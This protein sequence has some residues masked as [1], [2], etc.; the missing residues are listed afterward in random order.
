MSYSLSDT[1]LKEIYTFALTLG[2]A[3]G[4]ILLD[5]VDKR[6]GAAA[7]RETG[8]Q[9]EKMNA[10]DI[11]TQTDL[12]MSLLTSRVEWGVGANEEVDVEAFVKDEIMRK[13][14]SHAYVVFSLTCLILAMGNWK[15]KG[16]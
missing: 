16:D 5:G 12:G 3:A 2:R 14:P 6:T 9:V 4:R 7:G 1:E 13:Y 10:V 8:E 15:G 11:V